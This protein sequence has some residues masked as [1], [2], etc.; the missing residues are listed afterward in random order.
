MN[1]TSSLGRIGTTPL[2]V[3][4]AVAIALGMWAGSRWLGTSP[5]V[6][7]HTAIMYPAAQSVGSFE[8]QR[9]DG[10]KMTEADLRGH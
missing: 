10:R 5:S 9:A 6:D 8:L 7:V 2:I 3:I 1:R 4:A